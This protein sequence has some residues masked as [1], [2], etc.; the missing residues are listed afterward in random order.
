MYTIAK[1]AKRTQKSRFVRT[2]SPWFADR[3]TSHPRFLETIPYLHPPNS[4]H[5]MPHSCC[6]CLTLS[7]CQHVHDRGHSMTTLPPNEMQCLARRSKLYHNLLNNSW[8]C[9]IRDCMRSYLAQFNL[10]HALPPVHSMLHHNR[11]GMFLDPCTHC[12]AYW[13]P[14]SEVISLSRP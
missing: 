12:M 3:L 7:S 5:V 2:Y 4:E 9:C 11:M 6:N 13:N 1:N 8:C 14:S 10:F